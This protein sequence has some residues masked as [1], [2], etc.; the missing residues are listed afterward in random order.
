MTRH[1]TIVCS[2]ALFVSLGGTAH[3]AG[4]QECNTAGALQGGAYATGYAL[5]LGVETGWEGTSAVKERGTR[6]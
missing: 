2:L 6:L 3:A 5:D 4:T 1:A